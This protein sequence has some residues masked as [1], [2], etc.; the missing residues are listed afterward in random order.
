MTWPAWTA[1]AA[2]VVLAAAVPAAGAAPQQ[3]RAQAYYQF[4]LGRYLDGEGEVDRAV[5]A[6]REAARLDPG[7]GEICA[8]LA[9][10]YAREDQ[11]EKAVEWGEAALRLDATNHEA[12]RILGLIAASEAGLHERGRLADPARLA[13]AVHAVE[14]LE[15]A[16]RPDRLVD[17]SIDLTLSRL[18]LRTG[19]GEKAVP[20]LL[21]LVALDPE[22]PGLS[23]MLADA[24]EQS[25]RL[26][27]A[28]ESLQRAVDQQPRDPDLLDRLGDILFRLGRNAG[29]LN[30]W[31][32]ALAAGG[33]RV[34]REG[35]ERKIRAAREKEPQR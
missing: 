23:L 29:A 9:S 8:E 20:V 21:R 6:F 2:L 33:P 12:H 34:D 13:A 27:L 22:R 10:L 3:E 18:Y 15:S 26:E 1:S 19:R 35:L 16:R 31:E 24:Y 32:R 28:A 11:A 4:L 14:H 5:E 30:A 7:S 17:P 25:G